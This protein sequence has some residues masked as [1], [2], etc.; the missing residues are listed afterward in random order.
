VHRPELALAG[1]GL[2]GLGRELRVRVHVGERQVPP[3]VAQVTVVGQQL[4]DH[5]FGLAAVRTFEVAVFHERDRRLVR[6]AHMV[7]LGIDRDR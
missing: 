6:A 5:R 2:G 7:A 3:D 1:R 4:S